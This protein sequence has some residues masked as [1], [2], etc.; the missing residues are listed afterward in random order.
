MNRRAALLIPAALL[1]MLT[2][3]AATAQADETP[4]TDGQLQ[5]GAT[6]APPV[7]EDLRLVTADIT[8]VS[9]TS[10]ERR[11]DTTDQVKVTLGTKVLFGKDSAELT[12]AAHARIRGIAREIRSQRTTTVTIAGYTD[13]L[14]SAAHGLALSRQRAEAVHDALRT[15]LGP[16]LTYTVQGFGESSPIASNETESGRERNRRTTI[17]F[18][19]QP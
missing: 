6:L 19:R 5:P 11:E 2:T 3:G 8:T 13:D 1:L 14:G 9:G 16:G 18:P 17:S 10:D 4:S 15:E 12:A 7:I